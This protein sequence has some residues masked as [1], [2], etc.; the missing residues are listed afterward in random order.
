M[1]YQF[2]LAAC[3]G[4]AEE[5]FPALVRLIGAEGWPHQVGEGFVGLRPELSGLGKSTL[6]L[7]LVPAGS[8][9]LRIESTATRVPA[10]APNDLYERLCH[11]NGEHDHQ[12]L[13]ALSAEQAGEVAVSVRSELIPQ[14]GVK[15]PWLAADVRRAVERV[16]RGAARLKQALDVDLRPPV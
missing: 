12:D 5:L 15:D 7:S 13:M 4:R 3:A 16:A 1:P 14:L 11:W 8:G 10:P 6:T 2:D 9:I